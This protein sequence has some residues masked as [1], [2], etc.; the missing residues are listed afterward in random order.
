MDL[1]DA[2]TLGTPAIRLTTAKERTPLPAIEAALPLLQLLGA[3]VQGSR[4]PYRLA[5]LRALQ[6]DGAGRWRTRQV[7]QL[8]P[9]MEPASVT[10]IV[11]DLHRAELLERDEIDGRFRLPP[12]VRAL[13]ALI[14]ALATG[15]VPVRSLVRVI[16]HAMALARAAGAGEDIVLGQFRSAMAQLRLGGEE[17]RALINDHS[18]AALREA[19]E[20]VRENARAMELLLDQHQD[21]FIAHRQDTLF[22][23]VEQEALELVATV[24][25]AA[26][27]VVT[28]LSDLAGTRLRFAGRIDRRE[29]REMMAGL[30]TDGLAAL[31]EGLT[32]EPASAP[33]IDAAAAMEALGEL[34]QRT[35]AAPPR[36]PPVGP[37]PRSAPSEVASPTEVMAGELRSLESSTP[38]AHLVALV[39]WATAVARHTDL[40]DAYARHGDDLPALKLVNQVAEVGQAGVARA[41]ASCIKVGP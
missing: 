15:D 17:L 11:G 21:F 37:A 18:D 33:A 25:G 24:G 2:E 30:G 7:Q 4:A 12:R 36:L 28:L 8:V 22:L 9:W 32:S 13:V 41:S 26:G 27:E 38:V 16:G 40:V 31:V 20:S 1:H 3:M 6:G 35:P 14:D 23:D 10:T 5:V 29:L 39:D 19:G 34:S